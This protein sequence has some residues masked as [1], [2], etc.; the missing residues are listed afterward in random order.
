MRVCALT[1]ALLHPDAL[2]GYCMYNGCQLTPQQIWQLHGPHVPQGEMPFG[3]FMKQLF[4]QSKDVT[5][6]FFSDELEYLYQQRIRAPL[7]Q[8][9]FYIIRCFEAHF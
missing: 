5:L 8:V 2:V 4:S 6:F 7:E 9:S 3:D 1:L